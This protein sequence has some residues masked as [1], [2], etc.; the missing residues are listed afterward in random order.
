[1][2]ASAQ[3]AGAEYGCVYGVN[4]S[5]TVYYY[6]HGDFEMSMADFKQSLSY[7]AARDEACAS[8]A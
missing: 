7:Y 6:G 2:V 4:H 8:V 1:M 5:T 3:G